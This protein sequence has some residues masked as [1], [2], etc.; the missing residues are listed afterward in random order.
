MYSNITYN[1]RKE[2][3]DFSTVKNILNN[4]NIDDAL[5]DE[6][7]QEVIEMNN[8]IKEEKNKKLSLSY[9]T[10]EELKEYKTI[11]NLVKLKKTELE[12]TLEQNKGNIIF[13]KYLYYLVAQMEEVSNII[14]E[15]EASLNLYDESVD[16]KDKE[17]LLLEKENNLTLLKNAYDEFIELQQEVLFTINPKQKIIDQR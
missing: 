2:I 12:I 5:K 11:V 8:S 1:E 3:S 10:K 13:E 16:Y 9:L 14:N 7:Y 6:I 4:A 15:V 17:N